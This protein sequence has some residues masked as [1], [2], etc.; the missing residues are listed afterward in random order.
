MASLS[1]PSGSPPP[2][3]TPANEPIP[4]TLWGLSVPLYITHMSQPTT[5]FIASVPRFSYLALLLPRLAAYYGVSCSSFHHEEI[6]LRNLAVGLLVDLYQPTLP[7]RLA[8]SDGPEWDIGDTFM[9]SAKEVRTP[10][11]G[12]ANSSQLQVPPLSPRLTPSV[13]PNER[14]GRFHPQ[15]QRKTD[16]EPLQREHHIPLE[17]RPRR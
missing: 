7:W 16:H 15:W 9:N 3:N 17:R 4:R 6:Q 5:P 13:F 1:S 14:A 2:V 11:T 10:S 8:V 12:E